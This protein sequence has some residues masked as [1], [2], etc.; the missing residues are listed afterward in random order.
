MRRVMRG[1]G[2]RK[3]VAKVFALMKRISLSRPVSFFIG[4]S[5]IRCFTFH[6]SA[7][8]FAS[9]VMAAAPVILPASV[10]AA[11]LPSEKAKMVQIYFATTRLNTGSGKSPDFSG[12]RHLDQGS[13]SLEYGM[14]GLAEPKGL[15]SPARAKTGKEYKKLM[16]SDADDWRKTKVNFVSTMDEEDF[17]KRI[18]DWTGTIAIYIHGY[19]KPFEEAAED[20]AM[21]Y[22]DYQQYETSPPKKLLPILFTWPSVGGRTEYGTDEADVEWS[23]PCFDQVIDRILKEKNPEAQI[24]VISH[25]MGGRLL[26]WYLNRLSVIDLKEPVF[27][28]IF[29]C[30]ADIDF[31]SFESKKPIFESA[32]TNMVYVFVSDRD[33][34]LILSHFIHTQ[35]RLG[36]PIDLPKFTRERSKVFSQ[37]YIAQLTTDTGDLLAFSDFTEPNDVK[38]W[39]NE[40]P[41]LDVELGKKCRFID[42]TDL[43]T[44]DFGHGAAFSVISAYMA[45]Q[46]LPQLKLQLV[47]KRPDRTTLRQS[48]GKPKKLYRFLRLEPFDY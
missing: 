28:N 29:L 2:I 14:A 40:N 43:V 37:S 11:E 24:D 34:P 41:S 19:D 32:V 3:A 31:F 7:A 42:V 23:S 21:I 44:K 33:K 6:R 20:A 27:R 36:R 18:H 47:H 39:L 30:S 8:V 48:G 17:Y 12:E 5:F 13:G 9:A 45:N 22:G 35:P 26:F 46:H 16:R 25:S 15:I 10:L 4:N 1:V 38:R